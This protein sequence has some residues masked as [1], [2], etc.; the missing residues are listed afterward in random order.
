MSNLSSFRA[1]VANCG[2]RAGGAAATIGT[3]FTGRLAAVMPVAETRW[4][5]APKRFVA[6]ARF[7]I[8]G[9]PT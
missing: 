6:G 5:L 2:G 7:T 3:A 4:R 1:C 9:S 8:S